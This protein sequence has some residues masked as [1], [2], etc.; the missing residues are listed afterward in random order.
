MQIIES[1]IRHADENVRLRR[2]LHAHPELGFEEQRTSEIVAERLESWGWQVHRGVG[3][4]GVV[5]VLKKG[6]SERSIGLR[7]DM[8]ALPI[9]ELNQFPHASKTP[10]KMHACGHDGHTVTLLSAARV[11][12]QEAEFDGRVVL[13]FQP[14]EEIIG[15]ALAMIQDGLLEKFPV[16]AIFGF[17]NFVNLPVG[18]F[19]YRSGSGACMTNFKVTVH[20]KGAHAA[21]PHLGLDP[22]PAACQM[23]LAFQTV[24]TRNKRPVDR[25]VISVTMMQAGEATNVIPSSVVL[26]GTVRCEEDVLEMIKRRMTGIV[27]QTAG[28]FE[29]TGDI[30]WSSYCPPVNNHTRETEFLRQLMVE[31][32]GEE[33]VHEREPTMG[34]ED[35]GYYLKL[36]PG[37]Y[38]WV[39]S[40]PSQG[41]QDHRMQGHGPGPCTLHSSSYDFN[42]A[43]IPVG[44]TFWVR[45]V[46]RWLSARG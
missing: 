34:G 43:V 15:G 46:E 36:T 41:G 29:L 45:L 10:G 24:L 14:A 17:H 3:G 21:M 44:A 4:T 32:A 26:Q 33:N 20:G 7:A 38:F 27:Q 31:L 42:D 28:A 13:V 30:E 11:L 37:A 16:D 23:V 6:S 18:H 12:A 2:D 1:L 5:G 22:V 40:G 25:G 9:Q 39:G 8:D 35:F 19:A